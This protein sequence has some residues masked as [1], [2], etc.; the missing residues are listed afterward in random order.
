MK[1]GLNMENRLEY[2]KYMERL[3]FAIELLT[4]KFAFG[5]ITRDEKMR[6]LDKAVDIA[7]ALFVRSEIAYSGK[8]Q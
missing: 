3:D 4:T 2:T 1:G 6:L 7:T 5:G 8:K